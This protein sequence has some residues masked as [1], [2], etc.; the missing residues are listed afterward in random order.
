MTYSF[1]EIALAHKIKNL[2][3]DVHNSSSDL[4][5]YNSFG[6]TLKGS[7]NF[8]M[9]DSDEYKN[10]SFEKRYNDDKI[11]SLEYN[12]AMNNALVDDLESMF[13][14]C[15]APEQIDNLTQEA[16]SGSMAALEKL[17]SYCGGGT[18]NA[19]IGRNLILQLAASGDFAASEL[20]LSNFSEDKQMLQAIIDGNSGYAETA[21][22]LIE[23]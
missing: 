15:Y 1:M 18:T 20:V 4:G 22:N 19:I 9:P 13:E 3:W 11:S 6:S 12:M 8:F 7:M 17:A 14:E 10:L 2:K 5:Y 21:K 23:A 16:S